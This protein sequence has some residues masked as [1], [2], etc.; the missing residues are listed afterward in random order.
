VNVENFVAAYAFAAIPSRFSLER[1]DWKQAAGLKLLP[2]DLAWNK[3]PQAEAVLIFARALGAV[4]IG[5]VSDARKDVERLQELREAMTA[6]KMDSWAGQT[7]FQIT[8][9]NAWIALAEKRPDEAVQLMR[10]AAEAEDASDK[11]PVTPG[12]VAPS[13]ELL[14]E[15]FMTIKR[16]VDAFAEFERSLKRDPN[17]FRGVYGAASAAEAS[18]NLKAAH[19]Y[20]TK[21]QTLAADSDTDRPEIVQAKAFLAR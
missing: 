17:R 7:D 15:M 5:D 3:F 10:K 2:E 20:Y 6:A 8:T 16:P 11:H 13:R 4:R 19:N 9:V 12:N 21:L 1:G 18:G 14:G